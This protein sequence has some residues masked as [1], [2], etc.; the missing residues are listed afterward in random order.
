MKED[1]LVS[2]SRVKIFLKQNGVRV[3]RDFYKALDIELKA[4]LNNVI[5]RAKSNHRSTVLSHD[6]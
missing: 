6:L 1:L 3:S 4:L 5:S 2:K